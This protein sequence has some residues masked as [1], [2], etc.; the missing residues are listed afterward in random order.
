M[1]ISPTLYIAC[2]WLI[3]FVTGSLYLYFPHLI[4]SS[5][6]LLTS[7][8]YLFVL[9]IYDSVS[10][11]LCLFVCFSDSTYRWSL[12]VFIFL[13]LI[14]HNRIPLKSIHVV[15]NGTISFF[16]WWV[17]FHCVCVYIYTPHLLY[18]FIC[19]WALRLLTYTGCCK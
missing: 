10:V 2:L 1:T 12:A 15:A 8:N 7:D 11:L 3:Y 9:C 13:W 4:L 19:W 18:P 16:L 5:P 14:S 6:N 17:M